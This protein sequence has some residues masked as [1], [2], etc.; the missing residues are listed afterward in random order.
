LPDATIFYD[1]LAVYEGFGGAAI[2]S[3]EGQHIARALGP[4]KKTAILQNH[5]YARLQ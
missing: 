3:N 1:D 2:S 4:R 5:G